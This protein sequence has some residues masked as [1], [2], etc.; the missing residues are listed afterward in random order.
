MKW[1]MLLVPIIFS[2]TKYIMKTS[3]ILRLRNRIIHDTM[4]IDQISF[5]NFEKFETFLR[6]YNCK[7]INKTKRFSLTTYQ[8]KLDSC[9]TAVKIR[10]PT[11]YFFCFFFIRASI[12]ISKS[13]DRVYLKSSAIM[14]TLSNGLVNHTLISCV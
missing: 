11:P 4:I 5:Q 12:E 13:S 2:N 14:A 1:S 3:R 6:K 10:N 8:F 7:Y 9:H